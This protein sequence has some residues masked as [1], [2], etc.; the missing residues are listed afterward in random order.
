MKKI[1]FV[2]PCYGSEHTIENVVNEIRQT[3]TKRSE[4][5]YEIILVNDYSPDHVWDK[6][7]ELTREDPHVKGLFLAKKFWTAFS[8]YGR[9]SGI[10]WRYCDFA[11]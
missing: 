11:G 7:T 6:I 4:Y 5:D 2:I 1:S 8:A 3:V 9:V 10:G